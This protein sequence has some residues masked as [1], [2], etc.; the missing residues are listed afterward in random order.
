MTEESEYYVYVYIDPRNYEEFYYGK[1]KGDRKEA[2]LFD[3]GDSEKSKRIKDIKNEGLNPIIR[4]I[5]KGLSE[6]DAFL[7]EKTLIWKLGR[8][9]TNKSSGHFAEKFRPHNTFHVSLPLFDYKNGVYYVNVGEGSTRCWEDCQKYCF[10]SA[11]QGKKWSD[12]IKSLEIG[13]VVVA[14]LKKHGFVGIGRV[15]EKAVPVLDFRFNGGLLSDFEL[16]S[17]EIFKNC[18]NENGEFL[19]KIDWIKT[20]D[21]R[22]A[23]FQRNA[24]LFTTQLVKAS[25]DKQ[26]KTLEFLEQGFGLKFSDILL[27]DIKRS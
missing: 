19:V 16:K 21:R 15:K 26:I 20:V 25:L 8:T 4:V 1:G 24:G 9:L 27:K 6:S 11:G 12:Q 17:K 14:Y 10:I 5:A 2:H 3:E 7:I 13:D 18:K 23:R 22:R